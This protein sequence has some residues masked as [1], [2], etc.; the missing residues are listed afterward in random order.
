VL[1]YELLAG[2]RPFD[3]AAAS[4]AEVERTVCEEEPRKPSTASSGGPAGTS[5]RWG[6]R[7][8]GDLDTIVLAALRKAPAERYD[9]A[10]AL[11]DD[12][13]R[14]REGLPISARPATAGY[15]VRKFVARHRW[16][17]AAG[18]AAFAA[19]AIFAAA[20]AWQQGVTR[21]E[22]D[23]ARSAEEQAAAINRFLVDEM[24]GAA[25]PEVAQGREVSVLAAAERRIEG[26]FAG[27]PK[28]EASVRRTLGELHLSLGKADRAEPHLV[29]ARELFAEQLGESDP[30]T[31]VTERLLAELSL[32]RG[33]V[34]QRLLMSCKVPLAI[35]QEHQMQPSK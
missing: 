13:R 2:R 32:G 29:R 27:Q 21:R 28:V 16:S 30:E 18:V 25:A 19:L 34:F 14:F 22:R 17:V 4:A 3:L 10:R 24:L 33:L 7:L 1:L 20:M 6:R 11:A 31:L 23:R 5:A 12:V 15:R 26:S 35:E 9:S 8:A